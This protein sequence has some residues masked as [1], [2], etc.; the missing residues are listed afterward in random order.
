MPL[1]SADVPTLAKSAKELARA[2]AD[3]VDA[4]G[5]G[6]KLITAAER[7]RVFRMV[8]ELLLTLLRDWI[9]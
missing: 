4:G 6:G 7:K 5:D 1:N 9:D 8:G 2:V 3:A